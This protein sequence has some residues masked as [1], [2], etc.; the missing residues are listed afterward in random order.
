MED[1]V[2]GSSAF[3]RFSV[4]TALV[5][6]VINCVLLYLPLVGLGLVKQE[7]TDFSRVQIG[8]FVVVFLLPFTFQSPQFPV[9]FQPWIH[10]R[11]YSELYCQSA[12]YSLLRTHSISSLGLRS[13]L[14]KCSEISKSLS[15]PPTC[16][17]AFLP[18][19]HPPLPSNQ[20]MGHHP[21]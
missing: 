17:H 21:A 8:F 19:L 14:P 12:R 7:W 3:S 1:A 16:S 20:N 4:T 11:F 10:M 9:R 13:Q 2:C 15:H 18:L 6:L 5:C